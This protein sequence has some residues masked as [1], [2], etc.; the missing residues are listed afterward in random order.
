MEWKWRRRMSLLSAGLSGFNT[1]WLLVALLALAWAALECERW[2]TR[3]RRRRGAQPGVVAYVLDGVVVSSL[4]LWIAGL[5]TLLF[6]GITMILA[7]IGGLFGWLGAQWNNN[8]SWL[9]GLLVV[10]IAV[11]AGATFVLRRAAA[12]RSAHAGAPGWPRDTSV[13]L[14]EV[15]GITFTSAASSQSAGVIST[16]SPAPLAANPVDRRPAH[17]SM[18]TESLADQALPTLAM[19]QQRRKHV[20]VPQPASYMELSESAP[21]LAQPTKQRRSAA[22]ALVTLVA[23][24]SVLFGAVVLFRPQVITMISPTD[25]TRIEAATPSLPVPNGQ[26]VA[27]NAGAAAVPSPDDNPHAETKRVKSDVLNVRVSPGIDQD[28]IF[29]LSKGNTVT[30]LN[31]ARVIQDNTWVKVRIGSREG[32]V[33]QKLLE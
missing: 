31:E 14:P 29:V 30:L 24:V 7:L 13:A 22:P 10:S 11:M 12:R 18:P 8:P 15:A 6:Q 5:V 23:V 21:R 2:W 28:V 9:F 33:N 1:I 17:V 32:W 4:V 27:A 3:A 20:A 26:S 16:P 19:L 25:L